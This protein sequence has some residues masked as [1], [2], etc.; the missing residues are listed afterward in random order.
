MDNYPGNSNKAKAPA[1]ETPEPKKIEQVV[2]SGGVSRRK[3]PL[4]RRLAETFIGGD[5]RTVGGYVVLEVLVPAA[6]DMIAD[7]FTQGI[8]R[9]IYGEVKS[10]SRRIG[11]RPSG[12]NGYVSY[13]R[14]AQSNNRPKSGLDEFRRREPDR[15]SRANHDFDEIIIATRAEAEAV[16]TRLYD[17]LEQYD[18]ATVGDLYELVGITPSY[19]DAKW[20]WAQ[21][22]G[23][24]VVRVRDGYLLDLPKP[25]AVEE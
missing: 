19:T 6:R 11:G 4:G 24:G 16:I 14:I 5:A 8:E 13:N 23:A 18:V 10:S 15:R 1:E 25:Q 21:L 12:Q 7:A 20:G 22:A 2:A 3:T 17:I 9:M